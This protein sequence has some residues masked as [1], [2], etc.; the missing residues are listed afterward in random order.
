MDIDEEQEEMQDPIE[1]TCCPYCGCD[2]VNCNHVALVGKK[3][4]VLDFEGRKVRPEQKG[5]MGDYACCTHHGCGR[6]FQLIWDES[7]IEPMHEYAEYIHERRGMPP[8]LGKMLS[9]VLGKLMEDLEGKSME[10]FD[11][12]K[13]H[14]DK[15]R[16]TVEA[17]KD[18]THRK[19]NEEL[20]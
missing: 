6:E 17:G 3:V 5:I 12:F 15:L 18:S 7:K 19:K 11:D 9:S 8:E 2:C 16:D 13:K 4:I 10:G 20:H 14:M 1:I